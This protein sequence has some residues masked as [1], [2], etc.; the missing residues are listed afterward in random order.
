MK[1]N[2]IAANT[3]SIIECLKCYIRPGI[4]ACIV[5]SLKGVCLIGSFVGWSH[6]NPGQHTNPHCA[7][8]VV[9]TDSHFSCQLHVD[10]FHCL[11]HSF[12]VFYTSFYPFY[13]LFLK[14]PF[15]PSPVSE[16]TGGRIKNV[17]CDEYALNLNHIPS[18]L[19]L[20]MGFF[21]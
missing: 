21:K 9:Q 4:D 17:L 14:N 2:W 1:W 3:F 16:N 10:S 13:P 15:F 6:S 7:S 5:F 18:T 12:A 20:T 8:W 19:F 11:P